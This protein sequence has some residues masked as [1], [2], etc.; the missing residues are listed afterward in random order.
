MMADSIMQDRKECFYTGRTDDL[1]KHHIMRGSRRKRADKLGCWI[2]VTPEWHRKIHENRI[3]EEQLKQLCQMKFEELY[4][5]DT[6]MWVFEKNY[7]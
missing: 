4:G 7:L 1:A 3:L 6:W 2:W 5:H